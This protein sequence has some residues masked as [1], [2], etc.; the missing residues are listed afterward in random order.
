MH[1]DLRVSAP[2]GVRNEKDRKVWGGD[3]QRGRGRTDKWEREREGERRAVIEGKERDGGTKEEGVICT[4]LF[5]CFHQPFTVT[6]TQKRSN[7]VIK[8]VN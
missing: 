7:G 8:H 1:F 4:V 3:L 6:T 2:S 5:V